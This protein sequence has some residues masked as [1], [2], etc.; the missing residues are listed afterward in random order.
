MIA[1]FPDKSINCY[2]RTEDVGNSGT[3][4]QLIV[5]SD[6]GEV[7]SRKFIKESDL[8]SGRKPEARQP[9]FYKLYSTNW[10]DIVKKK[11][12]TPYEAGVFFMVLSFV[13]WESNFLVHPKT[14]QNLN[15]SQLADLLSIERKQLFDTMQT[16]NRKGLIA[17]VK[18]GDGNSN[19][20]MLNSN[21]VFWGSKIK[22]TSEH[23]RFIKD[24]P[25][26]LPIEL[27][28]KERNNGDDE[29]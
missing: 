12:L 6:T 13:G 25:L 22:D 11:H 3:K 20:Y 8:P 10:K 26:E 29:K 17:I 1:N 9:H 28:Y 2:V 16:L 7:V 5:N 24:C 14:G 4:V 23:S 19:H 15:C 18:C 27:K 21:V